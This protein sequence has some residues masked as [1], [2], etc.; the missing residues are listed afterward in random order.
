MLFLSKIDRS[1]EHSG[2]P[3][4][5][6]DDIRL[7]NPVDMRLFNTAWFLGE[8]QIKIASLA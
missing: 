3:H 5:E 1:F 8:D 6:L 2:R 7:P 4:P